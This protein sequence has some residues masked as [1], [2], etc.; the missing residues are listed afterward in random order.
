MGARQVH[1]FDRTADETITW[2]A[3]KD[4]ALNTVLTSTGHDVQ[5]IQSLVKKH[6]TFVAD[7]AA[8]KVQVEQLSADANS[9]GEKLPDAKEHVFVKLEKTMEAL[10]KLLQKIASAKGQLRQSEQVQAFY[11]ELGELT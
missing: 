6:D 2:L 8:V 7:I 10:Q 5:T 4:S 11:D 3:E 1:L 9:L